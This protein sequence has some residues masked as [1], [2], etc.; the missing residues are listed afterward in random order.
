MSGDLLHNDDGSRLLD[1]SY[2]KGLMEE[3]T[4]RGVLVKRLAALDADCHDERQRRIYDLALRDLL[5]RFADFGGG[6]A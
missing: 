3:N 6:G 5:H 1:S 4:V 2:V